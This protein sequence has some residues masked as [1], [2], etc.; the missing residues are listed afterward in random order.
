[1]ENLILSPINIGELKTAI[2]EAVI[3]EIKGLISSNNNHESNELLSSKETAQ[4]LGISLVT[5]N[6]WKKT[7]KVPAYRINTRVRFKREEVISCLNA[8]QT[9]SFKMNS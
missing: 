3:E 6:E 4:L 2:S 9:K 5:L 7:G 8:I 1:M